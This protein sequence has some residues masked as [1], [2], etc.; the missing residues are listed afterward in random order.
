MKVNRQVLIGVFL[1]CGAILSSCDSS[2]LSMSPAG[3]TEVE[4]SYGA[5]SSRE[6]ARPHL[7]RLNSGCGEYNDTGLTRIDGNV[8]FRV[9]E[10]WRTP[11]TFILS[12]YTDYDLG[13]ANFLLVN[14]SSVSGRHIRV[15]IRGIELD[16]DM[17]LTALGPATALIELPNMVKGGYPLLIGYD[18][19]DDRYTIIVKDGGVS[20]RSH[21]STFTQPVECWR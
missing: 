3:N 7:Q 6:T 9:C 21:R 20:I 18:G 5:T 19:R 4:A 8:M 2:D 13:C 12:M 17:C 16:G 10:S 15:C 14:E 1:L 11:G